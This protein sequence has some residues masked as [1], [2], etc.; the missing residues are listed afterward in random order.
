MSIEFDVDT[1]RGGTTDQDQN[2]QLVLSMEIL[3]FT[4][5]GAQCQWLTNKDFEITFGYSARPDMGISFEGQAIGGRSFGDLPIFSRFVEIKRHNESSFTM[6]TTGRSSVRLPVTLKQPL[7]KVEGPTGINM[8]SGRNVV[9]DASASYIPGSTT[10]W[11]LLSPRMISMPLLELARVLTSFKNNFLLT[12]RSRELQAL[13]SGIYS[14]KFTLKTWYSLNSEYIFNFTKTLDKVP[15]AYFAGAFPLSITPSTPVIVKVVFDSGNCSDLGRVNFTWSVTPKPVKFN[16]SLSNSILIPA[17]A[18]PVVSAESSSTLYTVS[19]NISSRYGYALVTECIIVERSSL[20]VS[21]SGPTRRMHSPTK[22]FHLTSLSYDPDAM[23]SDAI[24]V[25]WLTDL[26]KSGENCTGTNSSKL[27]IPSSYFSPHRL[28]LVVLSVRR[29]HP[30]FD[31]SNISVFVETTSGSSVPLQLRFSKHPTV[32]KG[33][34]STLGLEVEFQP[35]DQAHLDGIY[36]WHWEISPPISTA[37]EAPSFLSSKDGT[38]SCRAL[39]TACARLG[40]AILLKSF[41][42]GVLYVFRLHILHHNISSVY[43]VHELSGF[44]Y[45]SGGRANVSPSSGVALSTKFR[46]MTENWV[47]EDLPLSYAFYYSLHYQD[48]VDAT[49]IGSLTNSPF[50]YTILPQGNVTIRVDVASA[51][52]ATT[53][54]LASVLVLSDLNIN[55]SGISTSID[56]SLLLGDLESANVLLSAA[57]TSVDSKIL[58]EQRESLLTQ[59]E[60]FA[61]HSIQTPD[62]LRQLSSAVRNVL[63]GVRRV[64]FAAKVSDLQLSALY[65]FLCLTFMYL[66][67]ARLLSGLI[68]KRLDSLSINTCASV[69]SSISSILGAGTNPSSRRLLTTTNF[70]EVLE[71]SKYMLEKVHTFVAGTMVVGEAPRYQQRSFVTLVSSVPATDMEKLEV[72][73]NQTHEASIEL[74]VPGDKRTSLRVDVYPA[75]IYSQTSS[76]V[77]TKVFG[78]YM[79]DD[80]KGISEPISKMVMRRVRQPSGI[81]NRQLGT[82]Q[83]GSCASLNYTFAREEWILNFANTS[84]TKPMEKHLT[85]AGMRSGVDIAVVEVPAG[86]DS[87]PY[88]SSVLNDCLVCGGPPGNGTIDHAFSGVCDCKG[89]P[90][91]ATRLDKCG[92]CGGNASGV[93]ECGVCAGS[94][95]ICRDCSGSIHGTKEIDKCGICGGRGESCKECFT[96]GGCVQ[97]TESV[98]KTSL[99]FVVPLNG[100]H[101][102]T[103]SRALYDDVQ[104]ALIAGMNMSNESIT[105]SELFFDQANISSS[106]PALSTL[107]AH[108]RFDL[109]I[110]ETNETLLD[111]LNTSSVKV[112]NILKSAR[113][114]HFT[115]TFEIVN[116]STEHHTFVCPGELSCCG[117]HCGNWTNKADLVDCSGSSTLKYSLDSCGICL[118]NHSPTRN[119]SCLDCRG[120]PN[121]LH[122]LDTC[123]DCVLAGSQVRNSSCR[124][125]DLTVYSGRILD[126]CGVCG[127]DGCTCGRCGVKRTAV[128]WGWSEMA[129]RIVGSA[130]AAMF[131]LFIVRIQYLFSGYSRRNIWVEDFSMN[132][133]RV[134]KSSQLSVDQGYC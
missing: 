33:L 50:V 67:G 95:K 122:E 35:E 76:K 8:C 99:L 79:Y 44:T 105:V 82:M 9:F 4:G 78:V 51:T 116:T 63:T 94:G 69:V 84:F 26:C 103:V 19:V 96:E 83:V 130:I 13:P 98:I 14:I 7:A 32:S 52:G 87:V 117:R 89:L 101:P 92:V 85:C 2:C 73:V 108:V 100:Q 128:I 39:S 55:F 1:D 53:A 68:E 74:S 16:Q 91:G 129:G 71:L 28:Y 61:Q 34:D 59:I 11:T 5:I 47:T 23:T 70:S 113:P 15:L 115:S 12:I 18:L 106:N 65:P 88:S 132:R 60:T 109:K 24:E 77:L 46:I 118:P 104:S 17:G 81:T 123:G 20:V 45:P 125:C 119:A 25:R 10:V 40:L 111:Y 64:E 126:L 6:N 72:M 134:M 43:F 80:S 131:G 93:D 90:F 112:S 48:S 133:P 102:L 42:S 124:G 38:F 58:D 54:S 41:Q 57:T 21:I 37:I 66:Q 36:D 127:G 3:N 56:R 121:G 31:E 62:V 120:I 97:L 27:T 114:M 75:N 86:C 49:P 107:V 110:G 22:D 30:P 29:V